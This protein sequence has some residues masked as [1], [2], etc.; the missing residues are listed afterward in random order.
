MT[1]ANLLQVRFT[2]LYESDSVMHNLLFASLHSKDIVQ[3][4]I[5]FV[6]Y[7]DLILTLKDELSKRIFQ[8]YNGMQV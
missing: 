3:T 2:E 5:D 7:E 4:M 8:I 1:K 6:S